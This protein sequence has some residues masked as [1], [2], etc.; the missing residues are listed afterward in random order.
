MSAPQPVPDADLP[1]R[2]EDRGT[3]IV[4]LPV[5]SLTD[6]ADPTTEIRNLIEQLHRTARDTRAQLEKVQREKEMAVLQ[7]ESANADLQIARNREAE[8]RS[9]FVEITSVIKQRDD[10]VAASER[11][12]RS[13]SELQRQLDTMKRDKDESISRR[14]EA[15]RQAQALTRSAQTATAQ[16]AEALKQVLTIR[17]A[18][19]SAQAQTYAL[20]DK[21]ARAEDEIAELGYAREAALQNAKKATDEATE[22]RRQLDAA[23][24]QIET[25]LTQVRELT[26]EVDRNRK[27]ILDLAEEKSAVAQADSEHAAALAEAR[28]Q[29]MQVIVERDG[30]RT[31]ADEQTKEV[32]DLREQMQTLRDGLDTARLRSAELE[33]ASRQIAVIT[34]E[35]DSHLARVHEFMQESASQ[36]ERLATLTDQLIAAQRGREEALSSVTSAQQQIEQA[37]HDRDAARA[38]QTDR[39]I[40]LEAQAAVLQERCAELEKHVGKSNGRPPEAAPHHREAD[41]EM[42]QRYEQQR[43]EAIDLAARLN[44]AQREIIEL[45]AGLAEAR[46]QLKAGPR[47]S[48]VASFDATTSPIT[49]EN[50]SDEEGPRDVDSLSIHEPLTEKEAKSALGAMRRCFQAFTK[51][52]A[53]LSLLNELYA[54]AHAFS[55]RGRVSGMVALHR[56]GNAFAQL[57]HELYRFPEQVN[58][59]TMRTVTQTI[60]FLSTMWK[61]RGAANLKDPA[62]ALVYAVDDDLDNCHAIAMAM[63]TVMMRTTYAQDPAVALTELSSGR[64]DLI[65]LDVNMPDTDGFELCTQLRQTALHAHTPIVFVTGLAT[66]EN[67][68]QSSMSGGNDF[69]GK[70]FNLHELSV[71]GLTLLLKAQL[72]IS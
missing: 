6:G 40:Q 23:T 65:F 31:R 15:T 34:A 20:T 5:S 62:K 22:M 66:L 72:H 37:I 29:V 32:E 10:A 42:A 70:P 61:E 64:F 43:L 9:R 46:L 18:R 7:F 57:T 36:Q 49:D 50:K 24:H 60:E 19:D 51:H 44:A 30:A 58:P 67:R 69:V 52:P 11:Y 14:E 8:L 47:T 48:P 13:I 45:T 26:G 39:T 55:E 35:R 63:E 21:L 27:K 12:M 56:L 38:E 4:N 2:Q 16:L 68:V 41:P 53:D 17:Q 71:K 59:S 3:P 28:Q 1:A 33:E 25:L 54:H